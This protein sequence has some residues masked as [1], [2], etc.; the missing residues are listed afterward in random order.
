MLTMI[1]HKVGHRRLRVMACH[2]SERFE[3]ML[4][5]TLSTERC[6]GIRTRSSKDPHGNCYNVLFTIRSLI[7]A[8]AHQNPP[9]SQKYILN[10]AKPPQ[11]LAI[12]SAGGIT[13]TLI[14]LLDVLREGPCASQT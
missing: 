11:E 6:S 4:F 5:R 2:C 12:S 8:M 7:E 1:A 10:V 14:S 13:H 3:T 9:I